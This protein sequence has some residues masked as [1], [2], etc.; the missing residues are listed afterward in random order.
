M[1]INRLKDLD[2]HILSG[3]DVVVFQVESEQGEFVDFKYVV[4]YNFLMAIQDVDDMSPSATNRNDA[5]F[6]TLRLDPYEFC[7]KYYGYESKDG[8]W[9]FYKDYD[10]EA[11]TNVVKS[12][13]SVINLINMSKLYSKLKRI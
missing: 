12:L 7:S 8:H 5:I 10:Y 2:H 4:E 1:I 13:Y 3:G 11:A 9:P 6:T